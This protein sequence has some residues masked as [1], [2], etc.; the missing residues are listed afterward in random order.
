M[1]TLGVIIFFGG[2]GIGFLLI[3]YSLLPGTDE[4]IMARCLLAG[5]GLLVAFMCTIVGGQ[6][7]EFGG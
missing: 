4:S 3:L 7:V 5:L 6:L 1:S 2:I